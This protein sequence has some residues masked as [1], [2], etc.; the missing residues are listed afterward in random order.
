MISG[1]FA[2]LVIYFLSKIKLETQMISRCLMTGWLDS[3]VGSPRRCIKRKKRMEQHKCKT[4][5][6]LKKTIKV[7]HL[8]LTSGSIVKNETTRKKIHHLNSVI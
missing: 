2:R 5:G 3:M 4:L 1:G 6:N 8:K 7:F